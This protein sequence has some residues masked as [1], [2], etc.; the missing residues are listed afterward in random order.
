MLLVMEFVLRALIA[1]ALVPVTLRV[2]HRE[3]LLK[4]AT[5]S[6]IKVKALDFSK[7]CPNR[8]FLAR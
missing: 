5:V 1:G 3:N 4:G 7:P 2:L 6:E 8:R